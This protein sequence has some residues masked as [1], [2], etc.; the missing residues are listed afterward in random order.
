[1]D[2]SKFLQITKQKIIL[3][4]ILIFIAGIFVL[5]FA[6]AS[7]RTSMTGSSWLWILGILGIILLLG[8]PVLIS[9]LWLQIYLP[10]FWA[11]FVI[12]SIIWCYILSCILISLFTKSNNNYQEIPNQKNIS[13]VKNSKKT[14]LNLSLIFAIISILLGISLPYNPFSSL[15]LPFTIILGAIFLCISF[16]KEEFYPHTKIWRGILFIFYT[17]GLTILFSITT[18]VLITLFI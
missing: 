2:F 9:I 18:S 6:I 10:L 16:S 12:S 11:V 17:L 5:M 1:M 7:D 4:F 8:P 15:P 14:Y 3:S 13:Q